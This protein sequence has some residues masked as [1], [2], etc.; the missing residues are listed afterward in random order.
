MKSVLLAIDDK[1]LI[2]KIEEDNNINLVNNNLQYREAILEILEKNKNIDFILINENLPGLI[3]IEELIKKIKII[4]NKINIIFFLEKYDINKKNKLNNLNIDN[5]YFNKKININKILNLINKN[6]Y[7]INKKINKKINNKET[8]K[9]IKI[10]FIKD[11]YQE[12]RKI[13]II[14]IVK[15][16]NN[17]FNKIKLNKNRILND[18][19]KKNNNK[20]NKIITIIGKRKTGKTTII[21]LLLIYLLKKNKKILLINLN[22][23]IEN[24]Y[25]YLIRK[26]YYKIKN[27]YLKINNKNNLINNKLNKNKEI[28]NIFSKIEIRINN[29]LIFLYNFQNIF[30]NNNLN[31]ILEYFFKSYLKNYDYLL[32]DIGNNANVKLKQKIIERS[33]KKLF[34]LKGNILGIKDLKELNQKLEGSESEKKNSLHIILN[35]YYFNSISKLIFKNLINEKYKFDVFFYSKKFKNLKNQIIKNNKYKI[36][37]LLDNKIKNIIK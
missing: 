20:G 18:I 29:N 28:K 1:K 35:K 9:K 31:D 10:N 30:E 33:D 16:I 22:K 27:N 24:N 37:K 8:N 21:N 3:S 23:K 32:V 4:N 11:N 13:Q 34:I 12:K 14:N 26:K 2:K 15:I 19:N 6:N 5:I 17:I 7:K 36:N 25:F